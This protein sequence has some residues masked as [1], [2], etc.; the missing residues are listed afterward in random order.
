MFS[1]SLT[2]VIFFAKSIERYRKGQISMDYVSFLIHF[3]YLHIYTV[4]TAPAP[5][6]SPFLIIAILQKVVERSSYLFPAIIICGLYKE[7][8]VVG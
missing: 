1:L 4:P 7:P 8:V 2:F 5:L 3:K 6:I